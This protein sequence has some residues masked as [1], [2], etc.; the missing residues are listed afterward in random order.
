MKTLI[1][2]PQLRAS[3]GEAA[4]ARVE[5]LYAW[6]VIVRQYEELLGNLVEMGRA[7]RRKATPFRYGL[8]SYDYIEIFR[9]YATGVFEPDA[10]LRV[11]ETG[12]RFFEREL[13]IEALEETMS[14]PERELIEMAAAVYKDEVETPATTLLKMANAAAVESAARVLMRLI[15]YGILERVNS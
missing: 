1:E 11:T 14:V 4:R 8:G 13:R 9:H 12:R 15:K 3:M 5:A 10:S 6:P 2:N 7:R